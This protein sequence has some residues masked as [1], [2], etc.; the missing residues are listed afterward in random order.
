MCAASCN[1]QGHEPPGHAE[2]SELAEN[3]ANTKQ[4]QLTR[5]QILALPI[6]AA[7]PN[8]T[9]AARDAGISES[10]STVGANTNNSALS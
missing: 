1:P 2:R 3:G 5:R 7:A 6:L 4:S 9:Q 8:M 10:T